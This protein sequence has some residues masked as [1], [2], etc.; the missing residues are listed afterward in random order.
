MASQMDQARKAE[1][2][3]YV[4]DNGGTLEAAEQATRAI[5]ELLRRDLVHH[6]AAEPLDAAGQSD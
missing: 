4:I 1:L 5:A 6:I 2:A 3:D